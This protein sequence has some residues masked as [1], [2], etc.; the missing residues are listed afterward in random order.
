M[1]GSDR[2]MPEIPLPPGEPEGWR[3]LQERA[4]STRDPKELEMI[5]AEMNRLLSECEKKAATGDEAPPPA[6]RGGTKHALTTE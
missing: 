3:E 1:A 6:D 2:K 5:I 4:K